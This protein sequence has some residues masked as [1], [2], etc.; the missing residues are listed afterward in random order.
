MS[1]SIV[2]CCSAHS[3]FLRL[4][5]FDSSGAVSR[6]EPA[7][8]LVSET[9]GIELHLG[10]PLGL[11][12]QRRMAEALA[13]SLFEVIRRE[14]LGDLAQQLM[15]TPCLTSTHTIEHVT[16]SGGVSEYLSNRATPYFGDLAQPLADAI[17]ERI[18]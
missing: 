2:R 17:R 7:A 10:Q 12:D 1:W 8:R 9:L 13:G 6:I 4:V 3:F 18:E 15:L 5:A 11:S 16:F 14:P